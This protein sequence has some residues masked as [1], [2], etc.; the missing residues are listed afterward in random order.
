MKR[1]ERFQ[2]IDQLAREL[3]A[4]FK[5]YELP[6]YLATMGLKDLNEEGIANSKWVWAKNVL[7][8]VPFEIVLAIAEDMEMETGAFG[9]GVQTAPGI[10]R[11]STDFRIFISHISTHKAKATRLRVCLEPYAISG[12]VAH[13]DIEPTK[14]WEVELRRG[15]HAMDALVSMHTPGFAASN[16]TQQEIGFAIGKGKKVIAFHMGEDPTGFLSKDQALLHKRRTAEEI[17][18][19]IDRL[20]LEDPRTSKRLAEA[21]QARQPTSLEDEIPF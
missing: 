21:K 14:P 2:L 18:K 5:T 20:L 10:W 17:A 13:E 15:L 3:Q 11:G 6:A 1:S 16:W 19:E 8:T 7:A 12:F 9:D 4:R